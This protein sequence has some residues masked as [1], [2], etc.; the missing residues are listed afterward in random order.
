MILPHECI[1]EGLKACNPFLPHKFVSFQKIMFICQVASV[2][3]QPMASAS[4]G[5]RTYGASHNV[6]Q[7]HMGASHDVWQEHICAPT[8]CIK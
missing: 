4:K 3:F 7:E 1:H 8:M 6:W 2:L 5:R